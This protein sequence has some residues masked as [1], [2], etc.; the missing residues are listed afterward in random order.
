MKLVAIIAS[1]GISLKRL[2]TLPW[3][4]FQFTAKDAEAPCPYIR[5]VGWQVTSNPGRQIVCLREQYRQLAGFRHNA[6]E[7][8]PLILFTNR[9]IVSSPEKVKE[10]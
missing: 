4:P 3:R 10:P 5:C 6:T 9:F 2:P 1:D 8:I 7:P